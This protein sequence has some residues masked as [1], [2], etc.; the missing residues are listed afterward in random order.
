MHGAILIYGN[1]PMLVKTR[2]LVLENVGYEVFSCTSFAGAMMTLMTHQVDILL[3]CQS[4]SNEERRGMVETVRALQPDTK[5]ALFDF[6][7]REDPMDGVDHIQG[8]TE[9]TALLNTV[10]KLLSPQTPVN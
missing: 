5:C 2:G 1:D 10:R 4:L 3:L 8:L 9:P 7:K 6:R